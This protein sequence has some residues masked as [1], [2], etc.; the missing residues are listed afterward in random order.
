VSRRNCPFFASDNGGH[1]ATLLTSLIAT[2]KRHR[3]EP[4][5]HLCD[6]FQR[7]SGRPQNRLEELLPDN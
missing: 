7:V 5:A 1:V 6:V 4:F 2:C 3:I